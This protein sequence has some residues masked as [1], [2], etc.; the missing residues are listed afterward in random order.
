MVANLFTG[1]CIRTQ[2]YFVSN[3]TQVG[4]S[5]GPTLVV[6]RRHWR[7][8]GSNVFLTFTNAATGTVFTVIEITTFTGFARSGNVTT[9]GV[10]NVFGTRIVHLIL[11]RQPQVRRG[12]VRPLRVVVGGAGGGPGGGRGGGGAFGA[13]I[14]MQFSPVHLQTSCRHIISFPSSA[15]FITFSPVFRHPVYNL[16]KLSILKLLSTQPSA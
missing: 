1:T 14:I 11:W 15:M 6:I 7:F 4:A 8:L 2:S 13:S 10:R 9:L 3:M 16:L 12:G 5:G